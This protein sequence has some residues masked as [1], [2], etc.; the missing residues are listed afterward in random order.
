M[1][2]NKKLLFYVSDE[3]VDASPAVVPTLARIA[4]E[5]GMDFET[6]IC[7]RADSWQGKILPTVGNG[8]LE[9][10]Y[11]VANFY[12][13]ILYCSLSSYGSYPFRRS[14]LGFGGKVLSCRRGDEVADFYREI[15][16]F[17]G[18]P[19]PASVLILPDRRADVP[20]ITPYCYPD[21]LA[22]NALGIS[23]TDWAAEQEKYR[24]FGV[25]KVTALYCEVAGAEVLDRLTPEDTFGT[26]TVRI[27]DRNLQGAKQIGFID[28]ACLLRWQTYFIRQNVVI[29]YLDYNWKSIIPT[30]KKYADL[31]GNKRIIGSQ[32]I[33]RES[34]KK[35]TLDDS[36][37]ASLGEY[38]LIHNLLGINPRIGFTVQT[39]KK[40]PL[41]WLDDP[42]VP[43]PWD[44]EY[45]DE[46]LQA[47]LAAGDIPVCFLFYAADLGHLPV[48]TQFIN[49]FCLDGMRG[50]IAFPSTWYDYAP[51]LLEMLYLPL[52]QGGVCPNLEPLMSSVGSAVATEAEGYIAPDF[53]TELLTEA[54]ADIIAHVGE[55][56][57]P[58]GYYPFQDASP[59][60]KKEA[61]KPQYDAVAPVG[62]SYYIT[63]K[64]SNTPAHIID[65]KNGMLILNQQ[66]PQWFPSYGNP[67]E[68]VKEWEA[69]CLA[70]GGMQWI[71]LAFDTPFF[72][73]TPNYLGEI[74]TESY[75]KG[76]AKYAGM[77]YIM[78]AMQYVRHTGG[79]SGKL[80][81]VKPHEL[82]RYARMAMGKMSNEQ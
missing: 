46:E 24:A 77:N 59:F 13:E 9:Q 47:H 26:L 7:T 48:L 66:S 58:R 73:L 6:Y 2:K 60:Y 38:G 32:V 18:L 54:R 57:A 65:E 63:Y 39:Q 34:A 36:V 68:R 72:A 78:E 10:F 55:R 82:E 30:V 3:N 80:F 61:G 29:V 33:Y 14:V 19:L 4:R 43:T 21:V 1:M 69:K 53:L 20:Y 31:V 17:F 50:G 49:L 11:Y 52:E 51:E 12:D 22:S 40:L 76:W 44:G 42:T 79:E 70:A 37:I 41:D 62:Y 16:G 27:A 75:R 28:P 5:Q 81:L 15:Y 35:I 67:L 64:E 45:T 8:H 74:E 25:E 56:R 71:T 23:E